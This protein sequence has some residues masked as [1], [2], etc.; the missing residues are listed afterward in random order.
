MKIRKGVPVSTGVAIGPAFVLDTES[1]RI[2]QITIP[3]DQIANEQERYLQAVKKA[4]E[5][6]KKI[7]E[8]TQNMRD[9]S[10]IFQGH[11]FIA[12]DPETQ[13]EVFEK[14]ET[15]FCNAEY[16]CS[17]VMWRHRQKILAFSNESFAPRLSDLEEIE[18]RIMR[19]LLGTKRESLNSLQTAVVLVSHDLTTAQT[20]T[21]PQDKVLGIMTDT[22][23]RTSHTA[24]V[25][26]TRGIPAVVALGNA[27]SEIC[28]GDTVIVDGTKGVII[29]RPDEETLERYKRVQQENLIRHQKLSQLKNLPAQT[30]DGYNITLR[31][32]IETPSEVKIVLATSSRGIGLYR[33][34]FIYI[35]KPSA[36]EE[37]HYETYCE[38]IQLLG[39][40]K[41]VI[42]TMDL[43]ADKNFGVFDDLF[44]D[45]PFLGCRSIRLCLE[46]IT[47]FK[48]QLR[49]IL[50]ASVLGNV[51]IMF[52]MISSLEEL[53]QAKAILTEVKAELKAEK[54]PFRPDIKVGIMIEVP[55]AAIMADILARE[56]DFFSIGTNDLIQYTLAVD[57]SNERVAHLYKPAHPAVF[58][59]IQQV[60]QAGKQYGV[61]VSVCGEMAGEALYVIPLIGMGIRELSLSPGLIPE[62]KEVIRST[63]IRKAAGLAKEVLAC[64]T[65]EEA[66]EKL[67][68]HD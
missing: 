9:I 39:T 54:I 13:K 16:A 34:E 45:N 30:L 20:A 12:E 1:Y 15:G 7:E 4:A 29:I 51:D 37:D 59:L 60:V 61:K 17:Q 25:A 57:R 8:A 49:A 43:G 48:T 27:T 40:R 5:E 18:N 3:L 50:R 24:I 35:N 64:H 47:L 66:L 63:T 65:H 11:R 53:L 68:R 6:L 32:N 10:I 67:L 26:R 19:H 44:E 62:I 52:P 56:V 14:I 58:R 2:P 28:G 21:L 46:N 42:R 36:S 22:G 38:A 31:S 55:S 33:T 41:L 23:G